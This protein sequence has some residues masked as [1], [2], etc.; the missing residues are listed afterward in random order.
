MQAGNYEANMTQKYLIFSAK[1]ISGFQKFTILAF[2]EFFY[3]KTKKIQF[4]FKVSYMAAGIN[5]YT[6][7]PIKTLPSPK[8]L[9]RL[10]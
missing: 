5:T 7:L 4:N 1:Q 10:T 8:V 6:H 2:C 3:I 9:I